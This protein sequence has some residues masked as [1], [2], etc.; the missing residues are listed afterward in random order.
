MGVDGVIFDF[1]GT[2]FRYQCD[3]DSVDG[4]HDG[5][6]RPQLDAPLLALLPELDR[7]A[8]L[9]PQNMRQAW[10]CRD[11]IPG[12]HRLA[13]TALLRILGASEPGAAE[14]V[15]QHLTAPSS[16]KPYPDTVPALRLLAARGIPV[17]VASNIG[18]DIRPVFGQHGISS[19]VAAFVMS[20]Q[21]GVTKP[22]PRLF[23]TAC[24]KMGVVPGKALMIGDDDKTDGGAAAVGIRFARVHPAPPRERPHALLDVLAA[25]GLIRRA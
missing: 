20:Y 21:E 13:Y 12:L 25:H 7:Y 16:W 8:P 9:L 22:D 3:P 4:G 17:S 24:A 11:L 15:Y 1:S 23:L 19:C 14:A 2:L 10:L 5:S 6:P 18:W